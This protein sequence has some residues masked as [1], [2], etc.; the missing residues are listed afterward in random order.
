[1]A[2]AMVAAAVT[3][4]LP[5]IRAAFREEDQNSFIWSFEPSPGKVHVRQHSMSGKQVCF[6]ILESCTMSTTALGHCI[7]FPHEC[8]SCH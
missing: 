6:D 8:S 5:E 1:M 3:V 7:L 2:A 4:A